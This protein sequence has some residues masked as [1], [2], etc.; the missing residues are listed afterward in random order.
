MQVIVNSLL[1]QN[2]YKSRNSFYSN[3]RLF[4]TYR[5]ICFFRECGQHSV[6]LEMK[7]NFEDVIVR[8]SLTVL[9]QEV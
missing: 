6:P 5:I 8:F 3:L 1:S 2:R 7:N 9:W 4:K